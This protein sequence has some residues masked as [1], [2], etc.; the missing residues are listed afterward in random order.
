MV[1]AYLRQYYQ[2]PPNVSLTILDKWQNRKTC[3]TRLTI[4]MPHSPIT[5]VF[6]SPDFRFIATGP[7]WDMQQR[8][9]DEQELEAEATRELLNSNSVNA[10]SRGS[11]HPVV[12]LAVFSDFQCPYCQR[13]NDFF[14]QL[15]EVE[16]S[17][18]K[19]VFFNVPLTIHPWARQAA[20]MAACAGKQSEAGFWK[21]HDFFFEQQGALSPNNIRG[22]TKSFVA[23]DSTLDLDRFDRCVE[24]REANGLLSQEEQLSEKLAIRATPTVFLDGIRYNGFQSV[25][26]LSAAI[27]RKSKQNSRVRDLSK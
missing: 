20:E 16:R 15:P 14:N 3:Y 11:S 12:T 1:L 17:R 10:P 5:Q 2:M 9:E 7:V 21:L 4:E 22:R 26:A 25:D 18:V 24:N 23:S 27:E 8:P 13:F 19:L 6:L